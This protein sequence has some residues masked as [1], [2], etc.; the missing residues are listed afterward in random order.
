MRQAIV[1]ELSEADN[2]LSAAYDDGRVELLLS[3]TGVLPVP[4]GPNTY[5]CPI[6]IWLPLDFPAKPPTVFV[7][8]SETLAIRK[9]KNVDASGKVGV[10]YLDNWARKAEVCPQGLT[11]IASPRC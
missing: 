1:F 4:I 9:G 11:C 7:L 8:P 3:L 5:H 2:I 10:P 6:A